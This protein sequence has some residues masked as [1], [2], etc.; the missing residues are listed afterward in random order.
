MKIAIEVIEQLFI[1]LII[2]LIQPNVIVLVVVILSHA[3]SLQIYNKI[4]ARIRTVVPRIHA[5]LASA[6]NEERLVAEGRFETIV[7]TIY[8]L[9]DKFSSRISK[10][11]E[12]VRLPETFDSEIY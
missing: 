3:Q 7:D 9:L 2:P 4:H 1:A 11:E 6:P 8:A 5:N 10:P 12:I